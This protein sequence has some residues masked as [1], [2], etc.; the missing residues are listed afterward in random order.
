MK[1][2]FICSGNICRSPMAAEYFRDRA[3]HSGLSHVVVDS[4]G[5]LGIEG[6][7]ASAEA[8]EAMQEIGVDLRGHRSKGVTGAMIRTSDVIVVMS[9]DH[10]EQLIVRFAD[11]GVRP[12]L[13]RAFERGTAPDPNAREV[14]DPMGKPLQAYRELLPLITGCVDHL[15]LHV[16]HLS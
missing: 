11:Q 1:V 4:A 9:Y 15:V 12:F 10:Q 14:A 5:T 3:A 8:I 16:K 2:L 13:L 6:A 7:P